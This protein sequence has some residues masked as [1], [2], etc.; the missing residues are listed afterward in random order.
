MAPVYRVF[1]WLLDKGSV[2]ASVHLGG[3]DWPVE[4]AP[5]SAEA[6]IANPPLREEATTRLRAG[7]TPPPG[8]AVH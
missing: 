4:V 6:Q 1:Q 7:R 8:S 2:S 5:G 3:E